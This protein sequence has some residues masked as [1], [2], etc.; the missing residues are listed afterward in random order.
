MQSEDREILSVFRY[1][2]QACD[3]FAQDV[4]LDVDNGF[5]FH[6]AEVGVV[7]SI[8][9]DSHGEGVVGRLTDSE[10]HTID[11][12]RTLVDSEVALA[13]HL[14]VESVF[15]SIVGGTISITFVNTGGSLVYVSLYDVSAMHHRWK[16]EFTPLL[17]K[18]AIFDHES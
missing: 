11:S 10:R 8:G 14:A 18:K 12:D 6:V 7:V 1:S 17:E 2:L 15:E 13:S 5:H 16:D 9:N 4:E 3:V